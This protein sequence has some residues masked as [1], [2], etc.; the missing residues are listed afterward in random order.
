MTAQVMLYP[1]FIALVTAFLLIALPRSELRLLIPYGLVL[2]A[3]MITCFSG[4]R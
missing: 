4:L 1:V 2:G 3:C